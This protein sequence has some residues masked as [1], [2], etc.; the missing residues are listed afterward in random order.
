MNIRLLSCDNIKGEKVVILCVNTWNPREG[1]YLCTCLVEG[2]SEVTNRK[3]TQEEYDMF[4]PKEY[5]QKLLNVC[6]YCGQSSYL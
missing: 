6:L 2:D 3:Y 1:Y 4:I 5:T